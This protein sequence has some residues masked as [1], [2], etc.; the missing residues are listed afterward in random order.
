M[1]FVGASLSVLTA[2]TEE[3][4][5]REQQRVI[6]KMKRIKFNWKKKNRI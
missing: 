1:S 5:K 4:L 3:E 6:L 2:M